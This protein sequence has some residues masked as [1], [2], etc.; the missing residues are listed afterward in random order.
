MEDSNCQPLC[1]C[2]PLQTPGGREASHRQEPHPKS[3]FNATGVSKSRPLTEKEEFQCLEGSSIQRVQQ[4]SNLPPLWKQPFRAPFQGYSCFAPAEQSQRA[5]KW[6]L[7]EQGE[8]VPN[9]PLCLCL[10]ALGY[11]HWSRSMW[12]LSSI[13]MRDTQSH[14]PLSQGPCCCQTAGT[15]SWTQLVIH[16]YKSTNYEVE[17]TKRGS[18]LNCHMRAPGIICTHL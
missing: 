17:F 3:T 16:L 7:S 10:A 5:V 9:A 13:A 12:S 4:R 6:L 11:R 8:A 1:P 2:L 15:G 18:G 14:K